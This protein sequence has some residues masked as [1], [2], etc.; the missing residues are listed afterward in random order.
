MKKLGFLLLL[1][2]VF[3]YAADSKAIVATIATNNHITA[4]DVQARIE[5]MPSQYS[6]IYTTPDGKRKI[7]DQ[8]VEE[9]LLA[10][11]ANAKGYSS[12][13]E[14]LKMLEEVKA[15]IMVNQY[16]RDS[17]KDISVSDAEITSHYNSKKA[18]YTAPEQVRASHILV[19]TQEAAKAI[20]ADLNKG[21]NFA[22]VAQ[23][24][25]T[26]T[27]SA[28]RGGDLGFFARGQMVEPFEKAA[29][30][31]KT[32]ELSKTPVQTQFGWHIIKVA[33][34]RAAQQ[35][36]LNDVKQD[37][38]SELLMQKQRAKIQ[39]LLDDAKKKYPVKTNAA[40]L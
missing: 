11:E 14:V 27:G 15:E 26:D 34:H 2:G 24:L 35:I 28:A 33:E 30:A 1:I 4:G 3:V 39:T 22:E 29:F 21:K 32:G 17:V 20:I 9:K 16:L 12:N 38:R 13:A 40:N 31:L 18:E 37:I 7:L 23:E 19:D 36:A 10:L 8:L 25:S 5:T 6:A